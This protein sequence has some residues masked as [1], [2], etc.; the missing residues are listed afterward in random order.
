MVRTR[1]SELKA[2]LCLLF[3]LQRIQAEALYELQGRSFF[4]SSL[5]YSLVLK[6]QK[7][8]LTG[9]DADTHVSFEELQQ[10]RGQG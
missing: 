9:D 8:L 4:R 3:E 2:D 7:A 10:G 5:T 1:H 6:E